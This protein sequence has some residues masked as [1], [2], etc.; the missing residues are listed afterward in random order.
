MLTTFA[1]QNG[2]MVYQ[3]DMVMVFLNESLD[4]KI[5]TGTATSIIREREEYPVC[6]LKLSFQWLSYAG[7]H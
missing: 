1:V 4:V 5:N 6:R 7:A 3:K 2:K